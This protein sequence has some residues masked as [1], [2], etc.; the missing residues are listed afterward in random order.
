MR[1]FVTIGDAM[2]FG[3]EPT[4]RM[5]LT[6]DQRTWDQLASAALDTEHY[7]RALAEARGETIP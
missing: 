6:L 5:L 3:Q 2:T 4:W 7:H 1:R